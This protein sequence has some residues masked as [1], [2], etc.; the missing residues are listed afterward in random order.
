MMELVIFDMDGVLVDS[1]IIA[2]R[3]ATRA[4]NEAG[5]ETDEAG[6]LTRFL[7]ISNVSMV[8]IV[9]RDTG[10]RLTDA[11]LADLRRDLLAAYEGE[12]QA[13]PGIDTAL[14]ALTARRCVASSSNPERIQRSLEITALAPYFGTDIF[15]ATMVE[16]GKPA[17]DLFLHAAAQMR[18]DPARCVVIEDSEAG[19]TGAKAAGMTVLGFTGGSHVRHDV[20]GPKLAAAGADRV[21]D[22][23]AALQGLIGE[24]A[25]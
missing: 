11:F 5:Y 22:D 8:K 2:A 6:V 7:G 10:I 19:V 3:V 18:A 24:A 20:H 1:E 13:I 25:A 14:D 16:N 23:M 17:P 9:E 12:L 4:L 15:S 21:F